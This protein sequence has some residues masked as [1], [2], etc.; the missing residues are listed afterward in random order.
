[1][2]DTHEAKVRF[3]LDVVGAESLP[4]NQLLASEG[5]DLLLSRDSLLAFDLV[6]QDVSEVVGLQVADC[7]GPASDCLDEDL[8]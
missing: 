8:K 2:D 7:D 3:L 4:I 5:Q 1:M 6:L